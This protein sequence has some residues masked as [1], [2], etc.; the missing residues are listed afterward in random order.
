MY[1]F[2]PEADLPVP[3]P[4]PLHPGWASTMWSRRLCT[5]ISH[6][7]DCT[8][9]EYREVPKKKSQFSSSPF[10]CLF[11]CL[12]VGWLVFCLFVGCFLGGPERWLISPQILV[13]D[14]FWE[15]RCCCWW[16]V[17][18]KVGR[19]KWLV[20]SVANGIVL[21]PSTKHPKHLVVIFWMYSP[22]SS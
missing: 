20:F 18:G 11:L 2:H 21:V 12:L 13:D 8:R 16:G 19:V 4:P 1:H 15:R 3:L 22:G 10:V 17:G 6:G 7:V 14:F 5:F 9:G